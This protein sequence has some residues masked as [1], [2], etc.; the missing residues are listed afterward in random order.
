MPTRLVS[1][2]IDAADPARLAAWWAEALGWA[3]TGESADEVDVEPPDG[4]GTPLVFVPV[5]DPKRGKNRVHLDLPSGSAAEQAALVDRLSERGAKP[6][7]IGQRDV[8]WTVLSD[9]ERNEFCVLDPRP[10][11][12]DTGA[13]AAVVVD[14]HDPAGLA[15]FWTAAAGWPIVAAGDRHASLRA[16][17]GGLFLELI[18]TGEPKIAKNRLHL[19]VAPYA[20]GD[21]SA[22]ARRLAGLG[23]RPIDIGQG[24]GKGEVSWTVLAD[25][26]SNE[27][28]VL[29]PR[30]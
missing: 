14:A 25:P 28:C 15:A 13:V 5:G 20:D 10:D 22:E 30:D 9:P 4:V 8:P 19:D 21:A 26:E 16:P 7:D 24:S 17:G 3:V 11:Y 1:V 29:S 2:V 12:A 27:F 6:A 23:A 18:G